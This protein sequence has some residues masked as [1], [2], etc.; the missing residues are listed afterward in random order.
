M[1]SILAIAVRSS[2]FRGRSLQ[3]KSVGLNGSATPEG[4]TTKNSY[5]DYERHY[6][7]KMHAFNPGDCTRS[8]DRRG[9]G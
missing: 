4:D 7:K 8:L 5:K 2:P 3:L 9:G 1:L 6:A